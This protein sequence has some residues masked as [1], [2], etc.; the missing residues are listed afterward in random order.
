[1]ENSFITVNGLKLAYVEKNRRYLKN[2]L[3][4]ESFKL[5]H[6]VW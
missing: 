4:N 6:C 1:M 3:S 5:A 2:N